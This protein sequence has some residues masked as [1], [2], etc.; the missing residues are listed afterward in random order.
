MIKIISLNVH[1]S[2]LIL[3]R[4]FLF[5]AGFGKLTSVFFTGRTTTAEMGTAQPHTHFIHILVVKL[6]LSSDMENG[7]SFLLVIKWHIMSIS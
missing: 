5:D 1:F 2:Y 7:L 6:E 3:K 4:A